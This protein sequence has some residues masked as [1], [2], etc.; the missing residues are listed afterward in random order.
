MPTAG[1]TNAGSRRST[2]VR[3]SRETLPVRLARLCTLSLENY[4]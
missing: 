3:P 2:P 4:T 1:C